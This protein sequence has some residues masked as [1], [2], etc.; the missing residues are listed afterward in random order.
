[1]RY[2]NNRYHVQLLTGVPTSKSIACLIYSGIA[3]VQRDSFSAGF[4]RAQTGS[5]SPLRRQPP[6]TGEEAAGFDYKALSSHPPVPPF[7][8]RSD[9]FSPF[10]P[11]PVCSGR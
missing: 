7:G 3:L 8:R 6:K 5:A 10:S 2:L 1:M 4:D 11:I 9:T